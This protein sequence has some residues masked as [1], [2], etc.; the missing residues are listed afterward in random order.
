MLY[1]SNDPYEL[2][3]FT[4]SIFINFNLTW[5]LNFLVLKGICADSF[6]SFKVL[7]QK[8]L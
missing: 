2:S 1:V 6:F 5:K 3:G 4:Y 7:S 8:I